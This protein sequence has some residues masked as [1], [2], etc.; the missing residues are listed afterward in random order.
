VHLTFFV[1]FTLVG[2]ALVARLSHVPF[3]DALFA[4]VGAMTGGSLVP[5]DVVRLSPGAQ[6]VL[7]VLMFSG[8]ITLTALGPLCYRIYVWRVRLK[9][10]L[11]R[12]RRLGRDLRRM[13]RPRLPLPVAPALDSLPEGEAERAEAGAGAGAGADA[14]AAQT[15]PDADPSAPPAPGSAASAAAVLTALD[16]ADADAML[17]ELSAQDEG[18]FA[19]AVLTVCYTVFWTLVTMGAVWRRAAAAPPGSPLGDALAARGV[20]AGW[21]SLWTATSSFNNV[22]LSLFSTSAAPLSDDAPAL[23]AIAA[24]ALA[25]NTAWPLALRFLLSLSARA[26]ESAAFARLTRSCCG[27]GGHHGRHGHAGAAALAAGLRSGNSRR[28]VA[29]GLVVATSHAAAFTRGARYALDHPQRCYHLLFPRRETR[30]LL[31]AL[32]VTNGVQ[33]AAFGGASGAAPAVAAASPTVSGR[34][35]VAFFT[36]VNT[37]STGYTVLDLNELAPVVLVL[38][39]FM[40]WFSPYPLVALWAREDEGGGDLFADKRAYDEKTG[41]GSSSSAAAL[42]PARAALARFPALTAFSKRYLRR[43]GTWLTLAFVA[44][45]AAEA[46]LLATPPLPGAPARSPSSLF[47][48]LFEILSA[49]GT[50]GMS[51]GWPG[52]NFNLCGMMHKTSK[53]ILMGLMLLG[54]HRSMPRQ[55]DPPLAGRLAAVEELVAAAAAEVAARTDPGRFGSGGAGGGP[56][57]LVA[58]MGSFTADGVAAALAFIRSNS[59][60]ALAAMAAGTRAQR[61]TEVEAALTR[62]RAAAAEAAG[63]AAGRR[64]ALLRWWRGV[65]GD[66]AHGGG[67]D[68]VR[69]PRHSAATLAG[70]A[71]PDDAVA[72]PV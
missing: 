46:P 53:L 26:G 56:A 2:G 13:A 64:A 10:A 66:D 33:L 20:S 42:S 17:S 15:S 31:I 1:L 48:L 21:F 67:A 9:P 51:L 68:G 36:C 71:D 62:Q 11:R 43:H 38:F 59:E 61:D 32:V 69:S 29:S 70:S 27:G 3:L 6:G 28:S 34:A 63:G 18:L 52:V 22:G 72:T 40:M 55:V 50:N 24:A 45:A 25:G 7:F 4:C 57:A 12:A 8:G 14:A 58:R 16:A 19:V 65:T 41:R 5:F 37:R 35:V 30:A 23:L 44:L 47:A 60:D 54:R 49:Y 39:A